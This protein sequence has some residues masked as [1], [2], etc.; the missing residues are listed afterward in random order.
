M[1]KLPEKFPEYSIM[2]K[3]ISNQIKNLE[4]QKED[5]SKEN[6]LELDAK[7]TKYQEEL[8]RIKKMFPD[9]FFEN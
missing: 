3:T 1:A 7:I 6:I 5:A 8:D 4:K 2:Y 9:N